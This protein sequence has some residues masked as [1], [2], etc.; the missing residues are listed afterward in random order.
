MFTDTRLIESGMYHNRQFVDYPI[1][2]PNQIAGDLHIWY[3]DVVSA[4]LL[5]PPFTMLASPNGCYCPSASSNNRC[6]QD[7]I[8]TC[9]YTQLVLVVSDGL[10]IN[11]FP[12]PP[13]LRQLSYLTI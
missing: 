7:R 2:L 6:S 8:R 10:G 1:L 3:S 9:I 12:A 5:T 11:T 4:L 13:A